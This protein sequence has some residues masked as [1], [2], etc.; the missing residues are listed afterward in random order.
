MDTEPQLVVSRTVYPVRQFVSWHKNDAIDLR[1]PFQRLNVWKPK[2][3]S[4]LIDT[5]VR[6]LPIPIVILRD[7]SGIS[8]D[9]KR[10]VVDGQ[11][12]LTTLIAYI[13]P[14]Q[15]SK[16]AAV[17][18]SRVHFG[19]LANRTFSNLP[20]E[21]QEAILNYE[22]STH[23][24]PSSV[25]DQQVLRIFSRLNA[26][27]TPLNA[28]ELRNANYYGYFISFVFE[29]SL[30][31]LKHW[32]E[33]NL[34]RTDNFA[35][36]LE[37]EYTSELVMQMLQGTAASSKVR[38]DNLYETYDDDFPSHD[39]VKDRFDYIFDLIESEYNTSMRGS[40]FSKISWFYALFGLLHKLI[41]GDERSI[42][43]PILRK[44]SPRPL[45]STFWKKV[46]E[47]DAIIRQSSGPSATTIKAL[48]AR[49]TNSNTR[50]ERA[51][52]L[53]AQLK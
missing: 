3:K 44:V 53:V 5:V 39:V 1:P 2:A 38:L 46:D 13:A 32:R 28:Q 21:I 24:L 4:Y 9:L 50:K 45:P 26:T 47:V 27:G 49:T 14:Q 37:V 42:T 25:D 52:F 16:D 36:M 30:Q 20:S 11:Q 41:Y 15:F 43:E 6:G 31:H 23:V 17:T 33:W 22:I 10:E 12:R 48:S 40:E 34:F 8:I 18:L 7:K 51:N 35:R 29:L 19:S